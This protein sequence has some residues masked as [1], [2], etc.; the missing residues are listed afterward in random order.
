MR[1]AGAGETGGLA[2]RPSRAV[3]VPRSSLLE[4]RIYQ[5]TGGARSRKGIS[6][7]ALLESRQPNVHVIGDTLNIWHPAHVLARTV[8]SFK[9]LMPSVNAM[10]R[11]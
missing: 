10:T 2:S 9:S 4:I 6:L 1:R 5:V 8:A 7:N 3:A 11:S